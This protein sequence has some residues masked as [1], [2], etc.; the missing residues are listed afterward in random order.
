MAEN[1]KVYTDKEIN[2]YVDELTERLI[3]E[4]VI[5]D[6]DKCKHIAKQIRIIQQLQAAAGVKPVRA[7]KPRA[8][9]PKQIDTGD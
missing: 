5:G 2:D 7:R 8:K 9:K 4:H 1:I 3:I 6:E